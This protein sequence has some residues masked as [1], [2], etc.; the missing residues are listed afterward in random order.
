MARHREVPDRE[1]LLA[2]AATLQTS[3][4]GAV[5][6]GGTAAAVHVRHRYSVDHDYDK[7]FMSLESIA[8]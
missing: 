7:A 1:K 4:P 2:H 8:D 6:V 3:V 5:L